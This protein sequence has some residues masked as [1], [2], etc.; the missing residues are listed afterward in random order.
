MRKERTRPKRGIAVCL[1]AFMALAAVLAVNV[2]TAGAATALPTQAVQKGGAGESGFTANGGQYSD[3]EDVDTGFT[4]DSKYGFEPVTTDKTV[5]TPFGTQSSKAFADM[6][7]IYGD[8]KPYDLNEKYVLGFDGHSDQKGKI[9]WKGTNFRIYNTE[10]GKYDYIDAKVTVIDWVAV[11]KPAYMFLEYTKGVKPGFNMWGI[12]ESKVKVEYFRAG[13]DEPYTVSSNFTFNDID[14]QQY[15]GFSNAG[16][17]NQYV[18]ETSELKY[19]GAGGLNVYHYP[20]KYNET[21][22]T[23]PDYAMGATYSAQSIT[24]LFG[25]AH[26]KDDNRNRTWAHFGF[27]SNTMAPVEPPA[28]VKSVSDSDEEEVTDNTLENSKEE[29]TY[30]V[31]QHIPD[32]YSEAS[33]FKSFIMFDQLEPCLDAVSAKVISE[34]GED[35][36]KEFDIVTDGNKVTASAKDTKNEEFYDR[37]VYLEIAAKVKEGYD[38]TEYTDKEKDT[39][40]FPNKA[41]VTINDSPQATNEVTTKYT[42]DPEEPTAVVEEEPA[43]EDPVQEETVKKESASTEKPAESAKADAPA[44]SPPVKTGDP[45]NIYLLIGIILI[46][47]AATV[48]TLIKVR[49]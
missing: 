16:I 14:S 2:Q 30:R 6:R 45:F 10:T 27:Y 24:F 29:F 25:N 9:G 13:T 3:W 32:G 15:M 34:D 36:S 41:T 8:S 17:K 20:D 48:F 38:M 46:A 12:L 40:T 49:K 4:V 33:Y 43:K 37:T 22:G 44:K 47:G 39:V 19:S 28:P 31:A 7:E 21:S 1:A 11:D 5:V 26:L 18:S 42:P 23:D 35:I